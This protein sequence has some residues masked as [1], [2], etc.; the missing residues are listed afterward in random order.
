MERMRR[1]RNRWSEIGT[2]LR[3][4][5]RKRAENNPLVYA[6]C[7]RATGQKKP[8]S[9]ELKF[10]FKLVSLILRLPL[11]W[12]SS[13][14][15]RKEKRLHHKD[16]KIICCLWRASSTWPW[17]ALLIR[18]QGKSSGMDVDG[19]LPRTPWTLTVHS[20]LFWISGKYCMLLL[21]NFFKVMPNRK[22]PQ[23]K[24]H[25]IEREHAF[26]LHTQVSG[27]ALRGNSKKGLHFYI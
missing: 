27:Q 4:H 26:N 18:F 22:N 20:Q 12:R 17:Q 15:G 6:V 11:T 19:T 24:G 21:Q 23:S 3:T 14:D 16:N 13:T 9:G 10:M 7:V 5:P 8:F 1:K 25:R 2:L